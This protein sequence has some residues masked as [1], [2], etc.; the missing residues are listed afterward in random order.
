MKKLI[1]IL[2][3]TG[4][5]P[6]AAE[7]IKAAGAGQAKAEQTAEVIADLPLKDLGL[8]EGETLTYDIQVNGVPVGKAQ[9]E[10]IKREPYEQNGPEVWVAKLEVR[11]NRAISL[12]Y[13]VRDENTSRID[14]KGGFSRF[15]HQREHEGNVR[16][17]EFTRFKYE[18]A[19]AEADCELARWPE[20]DK[21]GEDKG[22]R[23]YQIPLA[24][25][26][27]DPLAAIYYL[28]KVDF[29]AI[30][31]RKEKKERYFQLPI[32]ASQ[33]IWNTKI[34]VKERS[35]EDFANLKGRPCICIV[36]L[37]EFKGLFE[38]KGNMEIW[39][40]AETKIPVKMRVEVPIGT[41]EVLLTS[42]STAPLN[43][44]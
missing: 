23:V 39:L 43:K 19:K 41:A 40:D 27:L 33:R 25:K 3:C 34:L 18:Y 1:L 29:G 26:V 31:A 2:L 13:E 20:N 44:P 7:E 42:F 9:I 35:N 6:A 24:G 30:E 21:G 37:A 36:P 28:R 32:C 5:F 4:L 8:R 17:E 15:F 10:I 38:R 11:S 22:Y 16:Q 12:F 14:V